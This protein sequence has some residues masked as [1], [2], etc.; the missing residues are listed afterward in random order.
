MNYT[1]YFHTKL[2]ELAN[3]QKEPVSKAVPLGEQPTQ[4]PQ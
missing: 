4:A 3:A 1:D 2:K